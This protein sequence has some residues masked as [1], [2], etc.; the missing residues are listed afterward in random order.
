[1]AQVSVYYVLNVVTKLYCVLT[2]GLHGTY[3]DHHPGHKYKEESITGKTIYIHEVKALFYQHWLL[4]Y[5]QKCP[6]AVPAGA[7]FSGYSIL[8]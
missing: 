6:A 2:A 1:M 4:K 8:Q 5:L 3:E 7:H